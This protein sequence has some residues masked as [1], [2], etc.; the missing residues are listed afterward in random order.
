MKLVI[1]ESPTKAR[2]LAGFLGSDYQVESSVGHVVDLPKSKLGVDVEHNYEPIYEVAPD[3]EKVVKK[4]LSLAKKASTIYLAADPDREGEAIAWHLKNILQKL[5][6][7][8]IKASQ[9][10]RATFHEITK[11]AVTQAI[12]NPGSINTDLVDAQQARRVLDRFVGYKVSPLLWKKIRRGLSAGRVQS[13]ALRLVVEREK[14]IQAFKAEEYWE[15]GALLDSDLKRASQK[16]KLTRNEDGALNL[17]NLPTGTFFADLIKVNN[18]K[19]EPKTAADVKPVVAALQAATYQVQNIETKKRNRGAFAPFITSTLQQAAANRLG[20]TSKQTMSL[21]QQLYE[22][23]LITY[24]RTDSYNLS[25]KAVAAARDYI[26]KSFGAAY[27][28]EKPNFYGKKSKNAQEA[29]EAIR[30]TN[31]SRGEIE[32]GNYARFTSSHAKLYNLIWRRFIASQMTPAVYDQTNVDVIAEH[33]KDTYLLHTTGS[34]LKFDGWTKL[35]S[36]SEDRI[37]PS[38]QAKQNL[39]FVVE[40]ALQKFTQPPARYNDA[41]IIKKLEELGIG[42]PSTY[43]SI[44]SVII[45]RGYVDRTQKKFFATP[46]GMTVNDFLVAHMENLVAYDFTAQMEDELDDIARGEKKWQT[47]IDE[48]YQPF[49]KNLTTVDNE[50]PRAKVPVEETGENCPLCHADEGGQVVIRIGRFGKFKSCSRY[51]EC[52]YTQNMVEKL[53]DQHCPLC[54]EG[55]IVI[56]PSR[57]GKNFYGCSNYPNCNWASW[58]KPEPGL[59]I[60]SQ[61]WA[62]MQAAREARKAARAAKQKTGKSSKTA[63]KKT[64]AKT[65]VT[66]K[67]KAATKKTKKS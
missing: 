19:Y 62:E 15:V 11:D 42:R 10:K 2:K 22:E 27:V 47:V 54:G 41:S 26:G 61:Q 56:K 30:V 12:E 40:S 66:S 24:H 38:L 8:N 57:Y 18:K 46:I 59:K 6:G 3:K 49:I 33:K 4:L 21:A 16:L 48:F 53:P 45:D 65:K 63:T 31:I 67:T 5:D 44:I 36:N 13:V 20:Y 32:A 29:H 9:F 43:A 39:N 58:S 17:E 1:V 64:K 23:G 55:E 7:K 28:P 14:E 25:G 50:A 34:Q 51:P 37:L 52:K 60:T 35:F